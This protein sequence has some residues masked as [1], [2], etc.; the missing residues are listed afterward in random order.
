MAFTVSQLISELEKFRSTY[1]DKPVMVDM[2]DIP[3][4]G[5][6]YLM[7]GRMDCWDAENEGPVFVITVSENA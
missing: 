3:E 5:I 4:E 7:S 1:G 6:Y 2:E